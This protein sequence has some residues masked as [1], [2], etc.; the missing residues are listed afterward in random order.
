MSGDQAPSEGTRLHVQ[1]P[2]SV[3]R[4]MSVYLGTRLHLEGTGLRIRGLGSVRRDRS[5]LSVL[6]AAE[7][8]SERVCDLPDRGVCAVPRT[9]AQAVL[10]AGGR[11]HALD[12]LHCVCGYAGETEEIADASVEGAAQ[13]QGRHHYDNSSFCPFQVAQKKGGKTLPSL[14]PEVLSVF[15]PPFVSKEESPPAG[16]S[17]TTLSKPRRRSFRKKREKPRAEPAKGLVEGPRGPDSEDISVPNGVDLLALPQLCFPGTRCPGT[18]V[19]E[20][21]PAICV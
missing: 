3:R 13:D 14:D 7:P 19:P 5:S 10:T 15:V 4:D 11:R 2:G 18:H 8:G 21:T 9:P 17:C 20:A 6:T 1:G 16:A 12:C